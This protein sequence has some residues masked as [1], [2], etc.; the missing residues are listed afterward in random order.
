MRKI[1]FTPEGERAA[2][3]A[4]DSGLPPLAGLDPLLSTALGPD[5]SK[6]NEA[7]IQAGFLVADLMKQLGFE[8]IE[9]TS[10]KLPDNCIARTGQMFTRKT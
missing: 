7:T 9:G 3:Q 8:K 6:D 5:Y 4:H 1:I 2:L 10:K